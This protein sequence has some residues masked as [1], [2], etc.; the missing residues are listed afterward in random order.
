M[1]IKIRYLYA[2]NIHKMKLV[3]S[4]KN[5]LFLRKKSSMKKCELCNKSDKIHYRVKSITYRNW[6]FCCKGCWDFISKQGKY[7]YGGTRKTGF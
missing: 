5:I 4:L 7:T 2:L 1:K 6:I 3:F